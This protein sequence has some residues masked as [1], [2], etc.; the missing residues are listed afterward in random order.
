MQCPEN[1][2]SAD[3][4]EKIVE[5]IKREYKGTVLCPFPWCEGELLFELSKIFT[6]LKIVGRKKERAKLTIVPV[7]MTDVFR[8]YKACDCQSDCD[9]ERENTRV[10]LIEGPPGIGKTTYCQK[11]SY[12]WSVGDI[13]TGSS[14]PKVDVFLRLMCRDMKTAN[15]EDA[16]D[17]QLLPITVDKVDKGKF[18]HFIRRNQTRVLLVLDGLDELPKNLFE[19]FLPLIK[20]RV[21]PLTYVMLTARH[22]AGMKVRQHCDALFEI[23]GYTKSDADSYIKKYFRSHDKP[24]LG[25][26][27]IMEIEKDTQLRKLTSNAL[28]TALLCLV[29]EDTGGI[30]PYNRTMLY[31]ELVNCVLRRYCSKKEISLDYQDPI[32]KYANQLNQLGE[33]AL[34]ALLKDELAFSLE[35][36]KSQSNEFL[37]LGFLSREASASKLK[38]KPTYAFIH[39]TFQE[40]FAA[41]H[42]AHELL[43]TD[44]DKAPLLAQLSPVH[45]YW[46]VWK[47]LMTMAAS[48]S[49]DT[50]VLLVS[51][52][53]T[54]FQHQK[55]VQFSSDEDDQLK[56]KLREIVSSRL[57]KY[58]HVCK[59]AGYDCE[60][61]Q[62]KLRPFSVEEEFSFLVKIVDA[63]TQC[64]EPKRKL[65]PYQ[66]KMAGM[67]ARC[68]PMDEIT[69]KSSHGGTTFNS[70]FPFVMSEYLKGNCKLNKLNW[71]LNVSTAAALVDVLQTSRTLTHLHLTNGVWITSLTPALQANHTV[72]HLDMHG[73][74][75]SD[76]EAKVLGKVLQSNHTLTHLGLG[77]NQITPIGVEALAEALKSNKVVEH[78]NIGNNGIGNKGATALSQAL[79][80]NQTLRYLNLD[81]EIN[82]LF[83]GSRDHQIGN[84]GL[85]ALA[86]A[87][88]YNSS[89]TYLDVHGHTFSDSSL[90]E[91]GKA[92]QSN[93]SLTHLYLG[94]EKF[95]LLSECCFGDSSAEVFS[96]ALQS[97]DTRLTRLDLSRASISSS[98]VIL[99]AEGLRV[100]CTLERL[101][102]SQNHIDCPGA[103]ALA[104]ALKT[105]QTLKY[106]QLRENKIGDDGAKEFVEVLQ[107]N[108]TLK[109]LGL[110]N[111]QM[112]ESGKDFFKVLGGLLESRRHP[113]VGVG[114]M[115][116]RK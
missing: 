103:V 116:I 112:T 80:S 69:V 111:N 71:E 53:C 51:N 73:T 95:S 87:L 48:K 41:F 40:Y 50:A 101:D 36:L 66:I 88:R 115:W 20:G 65:K 92:L 83:F 59:D 78:L 42:V 72:T 74:G 6:R 100:N 60:S 61:E 54:F 108:K 7:E 35:E 52:I 64:E 49:D 84:Q 37:E 109:F 1:P 25:L 43:T 104:Q 114:I 106:L 28:N 27:L 30:L 44:R 79:E 62:Q 24:S 2:K 33:L 76:V 22:E 11:L 75:V 102:L 89:L 99:L 14:F 105:N 56:A 17:D 86:H 55:V 18:F 34:E 12:D 70:R 67:L 93:C 15:I 9:C 4:P 46:Q 38:P 47:F 16:I 31:S 10:V 21:F 81:G 58:H 39:K 19:E 57:L 90:T 110:I 5:L 82:K 98:C 8:P 23:V 68:F 113:V 96:K 13:T 94:G 32:K 97:R 91:L 29:F 3:Y 85:Q 26:E 107:Y 45:D 63:I 77:N